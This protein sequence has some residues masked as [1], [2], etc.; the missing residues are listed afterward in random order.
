MYFTLSNS[1]DVYFIQSANDGPIKMGSGT[2]VQRRLKELQ[3]AN[4]EELTLL[5]CTTGGKRFEFYLH[6]K[7]RKYNKRDE[8]FFPNIKI[9]KYIEKLKIQDKKYGKIKSI[10]NFLKS[11]N[12]NLD[13]EEI[14]VLEK[15]IN[16]A[17]LEMQST[18]ME[19]KERFWRIIDDYL[20]YLKSFR[21]I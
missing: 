19:M 3:T 10:R 9:I 4:P 1:D 13:K 8:W 16:L 21:L 18:S 17:V 6:E 15:L 5:H 20:E 2:S 14:I 11:E 7:F 12:Y